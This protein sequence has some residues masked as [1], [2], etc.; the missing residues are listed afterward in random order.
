MAIFSKRAIYST[1]GV[2][3]NKNKIITIYSKNRFP[4]GL[5]IKVKKTEKKTKLMGSSNYFD[6]YKI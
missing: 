4:N 1:E 2:T 3:L 6:I 5:P